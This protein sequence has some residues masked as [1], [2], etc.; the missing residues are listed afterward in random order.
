[1]KLDET[2]ILLSKAHEQDGRL[3]VTPQLIQDWQRSLT[4]HPFEACYD[5][6]FDHFEQCGPRV[7]LVPAEVLHHIRKARE[8]AD[9][10]A[11]RDRDRERNEN[12]FGSLTD[13]RTPQ[14]IEAS[15]TAMRAGRAE[16]DA[17]LARRRAEAPPEPEASST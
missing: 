12:T 8:A 14:E 7:P 2:E 1:M 11:R 13:R 4:H 15:M 17:I 3:A 16:L 9:E 6:V 10:V 5:A